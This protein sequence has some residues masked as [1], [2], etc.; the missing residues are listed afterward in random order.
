MD[1]LYWLN[2]LIP[3]IGGSKLMTSVDISRILADFPVITPVTVQWGDQDAFGHVN[4]TVF[5]RWF[6]IGRID[7]FGRIAMMHDATGA[8]RGP[9][10]A[11]I[12]CNFRSQVTFP[13]VVRV[14]TRISR[15]GTSSLIVDH[16][17]VSTQ[18]GILVADGTSTVVNFDY[19][20][21]KSVPV[22]DELRQAIDAVESSA[23]P[24]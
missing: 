6:E 14:G 4:N 12:S 3:F 11:S 21:G 13:D 23:R 24:H 17:V 16:A 1:R 22:P 7:Y 20:A 5:L 9:I 19:T 2:D 10:L 18:R 8:G 15:I